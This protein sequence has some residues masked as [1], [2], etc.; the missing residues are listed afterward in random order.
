MKYLNFSNV[1]GQL[2]ESN[3]T[4]PNAIRYNHEYYDTESGFYYLR[5]RYYDPSIR[6]F[7]TPDPAEDGINWYA[8]CGNNPVDFIDPSGYKY[9]AKQEI[10]GTNV[11]MTQYYSGSDLEKLYNTTS[12]DE[13]NF[14]Y[15]YD[16]FCALATSLTVALTGSTIGALIGI[17]EWLDGLQRDSSGARISD[18]AKKAI[19]TG[20]GIIVTTIY[21]ISPILGVRDQPAML[22]VLSKGEVAEYDAGK[23][24]I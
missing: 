18:A 22:R 7:T 14:K 9:F 11:K 2:L 16:G 4:V 8:Y 23:K 12:E 20:G 6:R 3:E 24:K 10:I 19:K 13:I 15:F 21:T 17:G 1:W 5:G